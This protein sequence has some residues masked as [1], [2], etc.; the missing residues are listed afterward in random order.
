MSNKIE[1]NESVNV[2]NVK[3]HR[4]VAALWTRGSSA[5]GLDHQEKA[6]REFAES[7]DITIKKHFGCLGTQATKSGVLNGMI[8]EVTQDD[9]INMILTYSIDRLSRS[10]SESSTVQSLLKANGI[11]VISVTEYNENEE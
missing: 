6:C 2:D 4:K 1:R 7:N 5:Q 3:S 10:E 9:E 11:D 8:S